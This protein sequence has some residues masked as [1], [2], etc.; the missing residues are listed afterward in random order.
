VSGELVKAV[1]AV[2]GEV[3]NVEKSGRNSFHGYDYASEADFLRAL[4]PAMAKHGLALLPAAMR[5]EMVDAPATAKGKPQKL[6]HLLVT[7]TLAHTS[8][9]SMPVQTVGCGI[10]GED[11]GAYKAMTGALKYALRQ[12]F[13]V[14]TGDDP[15]EDATEAKPSH[16]ADWSRCAARWCAMVK[17]DFAASYEEHADWLQS[18]GKPRPSAL[19]DP[20]LRKLS[21]WMHSDEGKAA[22]LKRGAP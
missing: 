21:E 1:C 7:Y 10:D 5:A 2:M 16:H 3:R 20:S 19:S 6:T 17:G 8:G 14:P 15:E 4:Q 9:Q 22:W 11:K 12:V 18:I 13:L